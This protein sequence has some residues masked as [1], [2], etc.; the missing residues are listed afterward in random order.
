MGLSVETDALHEVHYT[1]SPQKLNRETAPNSLRA[2]YGT[3]GTRNATHGSDS[4]QSAARELE[5]F[6][7]SKLATTALF[8]NCTLGIVRPHACEVSFF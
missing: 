3:D 5:I 2:L 1:F 6:F 8:N 4:S 7:G